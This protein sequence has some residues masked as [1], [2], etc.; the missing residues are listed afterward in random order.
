VVRKRRMRH[1]F[2]QRPV[3]AE[4]VDR[5]LDLARATAAA[6]FHAVGSWGHG[7]MSARSGVNAV[8]SDRGGTW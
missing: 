8:G 5:L 2:E 7:E 3:D 4:V 6:V 1:V